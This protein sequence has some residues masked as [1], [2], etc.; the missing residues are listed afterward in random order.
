M[1]G[2]V[3]SQADCKEAYCENGEFYDCPEHPKYGGID[4]P[5]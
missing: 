4:D 3:G 1:L 2:T 5:Y